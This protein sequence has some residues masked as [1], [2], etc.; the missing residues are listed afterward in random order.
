M[1]EAPGD[2]NPQSESLELLDSKKEEKSGFSHEEG[3]EENP[4]L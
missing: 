1:E 4:A 3:S 2:K